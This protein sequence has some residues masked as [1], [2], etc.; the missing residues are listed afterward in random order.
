MLAGVVGLV[1]WSLISVEGGTNCPSAAEVS[2]VLSRLDGPAGSSEPLTA[3]LRDEAG[4][5]ALELWRPG[6]LLVGRRTFP[7]PTVCADGARTVALALAFWERELLGPATLTTP[8]PEGPPVGLPGLG[9][10]FDV[11]ATF[12]AAVSADG[13]GFGGAL[14]AVA[15]PRAMGWGGR[16]AVSGLS[17]REVQLGDGQGRWQ[18][19][20]V[21]PGVNYRLSPGPWFID[22]HVDALLSAA[23]LEGR[24][25]MVNL[26]AW[27]FEPGVSGG[28]RLGRRFGWLAPFVG[29]Q[30]LGWPGR[31]LLQSHR[32]DDEKLLPR[33]EGLFQVGLAAGE[34]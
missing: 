1:A 7:R 27:V 2:G 3:R 18:R 34:F 9:W 14:E 13:A 30:A 12:A 22:L 15:G 11:G 8:L 33:V 5:L 17:P 16:L 21:A 29:V 32:P 4:E 23:R 20:A 10:R 19:V 6:G 24:S 28:V 26:S 31:Q 25:F